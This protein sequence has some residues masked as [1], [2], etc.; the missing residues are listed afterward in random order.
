[1][2]RGIAAAHGLEVDVEYVNEYPLTVTDDTQTAFLGDTVA[3]LLGEERYMTMNNPI[4]GAED[5]SRVLEAVPGT[6]AFLGAAPEGVDADK[7]PDNH[8]PY[9]EFDDAVMPD[10]AA[11]LAELAIRRLDLASTEATVA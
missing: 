9:A 8:S 6:F 7:A 10:G 2:V 11:L 5:F 4:G 1:V 3:E